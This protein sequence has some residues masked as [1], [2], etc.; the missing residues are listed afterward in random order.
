MTVRPNK[1]AENDHMGE[2]LHYLK[3]FDISGQYEL[4]WQLH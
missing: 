2:L 4:L 1:M 3:V